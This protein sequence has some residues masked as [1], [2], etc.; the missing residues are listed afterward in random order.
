MSEE[1]E[2][3]DRRDA[4]QPA[5]GTRLSALE[6]HENIREPAEEELERPFSALLF[7]AL[8][9]GM[10][11]GFSFL[12]GAYAASL[13]DDPVLKKAAEAAAY[14]LGFI[15][16]VIGRSELFT[17]N[18]LEPVIPLLHR[19]DLKTLLGML[20]LWGVLLLGNLVGA[21]VMALVLSRT[22]I[23]DGSLREPL[24]HLARAATSDGFALTLYRAVFA[25]WL[26]A[27]L[28]WL[29][30]STRETIAHVALIWLCTAPISA[31]H[32]RHSIAGAVEAFYRADTGG[33]AWGDMVG[34]FV[35]PSILGNV[36]GGVVLVALMNYGQ[37]AEEHGQK[38][39]AAGSPGT[40]E[41][42]PTRGRPIRRV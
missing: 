7:S 25:G 16:V 14:P 19:R 38:K 13:T 24:A 9:A 1:L 33:A 2:S 29:L 36:I 8:A 40:R 3:D 23:V 32:F 42:R 22:Q 15:F 37:V 11:I 27:L 41:K 20:R 5:R 17:E 35:L 30:A 12:A 34:S 4:G 18:T 31:F 10:L 21:L 6:I 28:A 26:I 39:H